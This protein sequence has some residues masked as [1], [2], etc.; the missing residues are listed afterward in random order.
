MHVSLPRRVFLLAC[1]PQRQRLSSRSHLGL[2]LQAAALYELCEQGLIHD[3]DGLVRITGRLGA[4]PGGSAPECELA[5]DLLARIAA[6]EKPRKWRYWVKKRGNRSVGLVGAALEHDRVIR[7][8]P[9]RM[10]GV[11][12]RRRVLLRQPQLRGAATKAMWDALKGRISAVPGPDAALA[13]FAYE[14]EL[15]VVLGGPERRAAKERIRELA[16]GLGPLPKA[17]HD[18]VND[19]KATAHGGGGG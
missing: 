10:L 8:E 2:T 6:S 4:A 15:R 19:A 1:N 3:E 9:Y 11:I 5:A 13:V 17:L 14:G 12:P 16:A 18:A 7:Y